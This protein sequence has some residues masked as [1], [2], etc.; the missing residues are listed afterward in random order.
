M[1]IIHTDGGKE[2]LNKVADELY[3]KLDI[4]TTH[5]APA[6]PQCNSQ[7]EVFNKSFAKFLKNVVDETTLN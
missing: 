3:Q 5:T 6:Q 7:V 2:F 4:K 1:A